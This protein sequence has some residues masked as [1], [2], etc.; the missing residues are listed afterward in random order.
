MGNPKEFQRVMRLIF[1][2]KLEPSIHAVM[3]LNQIG[4]AHDLLE[5]GEVFGKLVLVP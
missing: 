3:P 2:G 4:E 1:E 5:R